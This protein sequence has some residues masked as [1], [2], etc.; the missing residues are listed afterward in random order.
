MSCWVVR[1]AKEWLN[2]WMEEERDGSSGN[3]AREK[4]GR[5]ENVSFEEVKW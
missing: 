5:S 3:G 2:K 4:R 1:R